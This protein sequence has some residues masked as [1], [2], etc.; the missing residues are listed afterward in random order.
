MG[1][2]DLVDGL[3]A[4]GL[5]IV[6]TT[7]YMDEAERLSD[8]LTVLARGRVVARGTAEGRAGR[9]GG[10]ARR[11]AGRAAAGAR[12][13]RRGSRRAAAARRPACSAPGTC[14]LAARSWRT[15][16]ARFP[17]LRYEVRAPHPRRS[18][19]QAGARAVTLA[20]RRRRLAEP[21][22][23]GAPPAR[24]PAELAH[25]VPAA[26]AGAGDDAA[27]LRRRPRRLRGAASTWQGRPIEYMTYVA[28]GM[29][30]YATFMT[31]IFQSLFG[32]FIRMRYQR[33][34]EGQ[35]TT[36]IELH[37]RGVGRGAVGGAPGHDV[38]GDRGRGARRLPRARAPRRS[39]LGL[40]AR[41]AA[42]R[43]RGRLRVR[44]ARPLLHRDRCRPSTT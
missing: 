22:R 14:R 34:W 16:R 9:P 33:T 13:W 28:P 36:Q 10:R 31:A 29:L 30:A 40:A 32:A 37:A 44:G 35:L 24:V 4:E 39:T 3:R 41:A 42:R 18:L 5:G 17:S 43:V 38:R 21:R 15:S 8:A 20:D 6:L 11:R 12:R 19:P 26:G 27:R 7:H 2:W 25:G 1:V 23:G